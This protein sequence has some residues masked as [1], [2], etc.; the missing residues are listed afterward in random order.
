M[1]TR[2]TKLWVIRPSSIRSWHL[3]MPSR[4]TSSRNVDK[5]STRTSTTQ[6]TYPKKM[7]TQTSN[8]GTPCWTVC[9]W[10][11]LN[12]RSTTKESERRSIHLCSKA[13]TQQAVPSCSSSYRL[14]TIRM[15][16]SAC[17]RRSTQ[18]STIGAT[19]RHR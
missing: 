8:S 10:R 1:K 2:C 6:Q 15:F 9:C 12:N 7:S 5:C 19:Q 17:T 11:K 14:P 13:T 4:G 18:H 16:R 3:S